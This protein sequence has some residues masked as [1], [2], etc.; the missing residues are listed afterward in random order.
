MSKE[1]ELSLVERLREKDHTNAM[2]EVMIRSPLAHSRANELTTSDNATS[3]KHPKGTVPALA[4]SLM[5][6]SYLN[7]KAPDAQ[8][9]AEISSTLHLTKS[10]CH[11]ILRTLVYFEWLAFDDRN[12]TYKLLPS[13][14]SDLSSLFTSPL[15]ETVRV[16]L[17]DFVDQLDLPCVL[18]Q[19]LTD[20]SF[21]VID[22]FRCRRY[23]DAFYTVGHR[24]PH[25]ASAHMRALIAWSGKERIQ[26]HLA[27]WK[28]KKYTDFTPMTRKQI[29]D[30]LVATRK[31]GYALSIDELSD[32]LTAIAMPIFDRNGEV[33]YIASCSFLS[34]EHDF[35]Y[36]EISAKLRKAIDHIHLQSVATVP[37]EFRIVR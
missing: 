4:N 23:I 8:T 33:V 31:R 28:P 29:E 30:E 22:T 35:N 2:R 11:S 15:L 18:A 25:N 27:E 36:Q 13:A 37:A 21:V 34:R 7:S 26:K 14:I 1:D 19:P 9:L 32:N 10:H 12:K 3:L 16:C 20:G 6:I 5:V 24:F 17:S